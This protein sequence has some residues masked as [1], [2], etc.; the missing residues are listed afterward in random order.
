[1]KKVVL[2]IVL[3]ALYT[4][5]ALADMM[6]TVADSG[7]GSTNGGEFTVTVTGDPIGNFYDNT[8]PNNTLGTF[9][10]ETAEYL[11]YGTTYFVTL[12]DYSIKGRYTLPPYD[13]LDPMTA[14]IYT[15][16]LNNNLAHDDATADAVQNAI[17]YIEGE[18]GS[19]NQLVTDAQLAIKDGWVNT[20]IKV[21]N[22]WGNAAHTDY[23]QDLLVRVPLPGAVLLGVL[24][25]SIAGLKLRKYT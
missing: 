21:M 25:L 23:K 17:W 3:C 9:C 13:P 10:L 1:M 12:S 15:Q 11:N 18:G 8:P 2:I 14:W 24:G 22:L 5:P 16:W 20:D 6:I 7:V 19:T 4:A